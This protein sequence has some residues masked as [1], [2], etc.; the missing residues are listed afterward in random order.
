MDAIKDYPTDKKIHISDKPNDIDGIVCQALFGEH[1]TQVIEQDQLIDE[2]LGSCEV[3]ILSS[4]SKENCSL[5]YKS[6]LNNKCKFYLLKHLDFVEEGFSDDDIFKLMIYNLELFRRKSVR[7]KSNYITRESLKDINKSDYDKIFNIELLNKSPLLFTNLYRVIALEKQEPLTFI[8]SLLDE[9][10]NEIKTSFL[11]SLVNIVF[12]AGSETPFCKTLIDHF[13]NIAYSES[14]HKFYIFLL[15]NKIYERM[16]ETTIRNINFSHAPIISYCICKD[17][18][19][20]YLN[21]LNKFVEKH[22]PLTVNGTIIYILIYSKIFDN[23]K[24]FQ[25]F[26]A[27]VKEPSSKNENAYHELFLKVEILLKEKEVSALPP[28][29]LQEGVDQYI[30]YVLDKNSPEQPAVLFNLLVEMPS[31]AI[32]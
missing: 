14:I 5:A 1:T 21:I 19:G 22:P 16:N 7:A 8:F 30:K 15:L 12:Y 3:I 26:K 28:L 9:Y 29:Q 10:D 13:L 17:P 20:E 11:D 24:Y 23:D 32:S 31:K 6:Y 4:A 27:K 2:I 18:E 25:E